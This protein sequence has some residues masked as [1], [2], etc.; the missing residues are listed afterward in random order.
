[1]AKH[2][3]PNGITIDVPDDVTIEN[4]DA[5]ERKT[6]GGRKPLRRGAIGV[7]GGGQDSVEGN[8]VVDAMVA[9]DLTLVDS[10]DITL[11]GP[12]ARTRGVRAPS[13]LTVD[14][15]ENEDSVVLFEQDGVYSWRYPDSTEPITAQP[16][17]RGPVR[18][19]PRRRVTF[20]LSV[21]PTPEAAARRTRG[22]I[23]DFVIGK[24]RAYV[25]RFVARVGVES[26]IG[27]L[28]RKKR[29]GL[30]HMNVDDPSRWSPI[31][32]LDAL[33]LP[34]DRAARILLFVH[35]T[36]S[37][38]LGSYGALG[39]TEWGRAFL[40]R[41]RASYDAIIGYDHRTLSRD[42]LQNAEDLLGR[43]ERTTAPALEIDAVAFSRGALVLR[44]LI[45]Y[46]LP[47][48]SLRAR[49][50]RA[51]FVG[52]TNSG[53]QL[54]A[55]ENWTRLIDL[56]TNL[57]AVGCR[58]LS[59]FG[60]TA[61]AAT[62]VRESVDTLGALVKGLAAAVLSEDVVPGLAAMVPTGRFVTEI[63]K[64]QTGQ[65]TASESLYYAVSSDFDVQS[66]LEGKGAAEF[67]ARLARWAADAIVDSAMRE[68][69]DLVVNTASMT[70][71][72]PDSGVF[73]KGRWHFERNPYVYHTIYFTREE[74]VRAMTRWL[75]L[76]PA[77]TRG[78]P[79]DNVPAGADNRIFVIEAYESLATTIDTIRAKT[80]TFVIAERSA[81]EGG[82]F[83]YAY[84]S[85]ELIRLGMSLGP[86]AMVRSLEH[87]VRGTPLEMSES[88]STP[89]ASGDSVGT[90][91]MRS[92]PT[93][94]RLIVLDGDAIRAVIERGASMTSNVELA[95][96]AKRAAEPAT[97]APPPTPAFGPAIRGR[98]R[99]RGGAG[100]GG[101]RRGPADVSTNRAAAAP[102][103]ATVF[104][105]GEMPE[106]IPV[107]IAVP[108][109][110]IVSQEEVVVTA[111]LT[112]AAA[113]ATVAPDRTVL[114]QV[115]PKQNLIVEGDDRAEI[116]P[117]SPRTDLVFEVKGVTAGAGEIW[118][119][120]RQGPIVLATLKLLPQVVAGIAQPSAARTREAVDAESADPETA[121]YP[122]LQIF[123]WNGGG[124]FKYHFV[125]QLE[126]GNYISGYSDEIRQSR[127]EYVTRLYKEIEDRW[128]STNGDY[129]AFQDEL[130][131]YGATLF[132]ELVP[133]GVQ[134]ALW[135]VRDT[136]T[137]IQV[138]AEEPFIPWELVH[139]KPPRAANGQPAPLPADM[140][141]LAQKGLVRW[142]HN[143]GSAPLRLTVRK[144]C[145]YY[146][147]PEYPPPNDLPQA[148]AE[149]PFLKK[150]FGSKEVA[151]DLSAIRDLLRTPGT[152]DHFH[153]SGHGEADGEKAVDAQLILAGTVE[154]NKWVPRYLKA[155]FIANMAVLTGTGGER[156]LVVLN[157]CQV[158]R[159]GWR[160]S[161][162]G[163]FAESFLR[164]GAGV[165]V[166]S[167]WSVG[168]E[169][170][171]QFSESF[172]E[173]L[174]TGATLTRATI[175]GRE[176]AR[177]AQE[178]TW[179][180]Y[181]VYGYPHAIVRIQSP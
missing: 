126:P 42:P 175:A 124:A 28:E 94:E 49:V 57:V 10:F 66:I 105:A 134:D 114:V 85:E 33:S 2:E 54:A 145:S 95:E 97:L 74:V 168:D 59:A 46:L 164:A 84:R 156:P 157:A 151:A 101:A 19:R 111:G 80:P 8:P 112:R 79:E 136:L 170:A 55:K 118:V 140:H 62:I 102:P 96:V 67:P 142:L 135:A 29:S 116:D 50:R 120:L 146:V 130:R 159:A 16:A 58:A 83:Y 77:I 106:S 5:V 133:P 35:G 167:L 122:V 47:G 109:N 115:I 148:Q 171:H 31:E 150:T 91:A 125:L 3:R 81:P 177:K 18:V 165:F 180:A 43:L 13:R 117:T 149:I 26:A 144:G 6:S 25:F 155:D 98:G 132:D 129:N 36:F 69:N 160:L 20:D 127:G 99:T 53:T 121:T 37:S 110:V 1:M 88:T 103:R 93:G 63:N 12:T 128:L 179:L 169:P 72:D 161:S 4:G 104:V 137:A 86:A 119:L 131:T 73:I 176:A 154:N 78:T 27:F 48:A 166:G 90:V 7:T 100:G 108:L 51:I 153:F 82:R 113:K 123:E 56:S 178:G 163:G 17:R 92:G 32:R 23:A 173:A 22:P 44:S 107:G 24:V 30:V 71:I 181:V 41:A 40:A 143:R 38:T 39:V 158:G 172:Y 152:V 14:V 70:A 52:G 9:Q 174:R 65:P 139:L 11:A 64:A 162:I 75:G 21:E 76:D 87:A 147:V 61:L 89:E 15:D 45:E 138:V 60:S 141:F 34:T 68:A